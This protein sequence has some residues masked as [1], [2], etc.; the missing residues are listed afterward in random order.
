VVQAEFLRL[1]GGT[2][3]AEISSNALGTGDGGSVQ[4]KV[5]GLLELVHGGMIS[6]S[7][8]AEGCAGDINIE[9][10]EI[11]MANQGSGWGTTLNA[12]ANPDSTGN[13]GNIK[14]RADHSLRIMDGAQIITSTFATGDAGGIDMEMGSLYVEGTDAGDLYTGI[15]SSVEPGASGNGGPTRVVVHGKAEL[16]G[17][18]SLSNAIRG[19]G[20]AGDIIMRADELFIDGV[21]IF[22]PSEISSEALT[23]DSGNV[24]FLDIQARRLVMT[25]G[26]EI[27]IASEQTLPVT[28]QNRRPAALATDP[29]GHIQV[30]ANDLLLHSGAHITAES[31]GDVPA[32][33]IEIKADNMVLVGGGQ[34]TTESKVADGG[35]IRIDGGILRVSDS[36]I[37]TSVGGE[38]GNGGDIALSPDLLVLDG[39]FIQANTAAPQASGG[40]ILIDTKALVASGGEVQVGGTERAEFQ[41][42]RGINVI[43]AAAPGGEQGTITITA[44]ELDISGTLAKL[45]SGFYKPAQLI[46]DPCAVLTG[47]APSSLVQGTRGGIPAGPKGPASVSFGGARL[48]RL[49]SAPLAPVGKSDSSMT[50]PSGEESGAVGDRVD[51]CRLRETL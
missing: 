14:V 47:K 42:G 4:V 41:A 24:G 26:G 27:S 6:T 45:A 32:G 23:N 17:G 33:A 48:D 7:T 12:A 3:T 31:T 25:N 2:T 1:H 28:T 34:I 50:D 38:R 43:Q 15:F 5:G 13:G 40:D 51:R 36:L 18:G 16:R 44:P 20:D 35:P 29:T 19:K 21:G 8:F 46:G 30:H 39:G 10:G 9:A 11:H 22:G 37:T 49:L